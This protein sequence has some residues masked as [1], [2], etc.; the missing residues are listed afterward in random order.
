MLYLAISKTTRMDG[1]AQKGAVG[2]SAVRARRMTVAGSLALLLAAILALCLA[3]SGGAALSERA[4]ADDQ[5]AQLA[6]PAKTGR[7]T[8]S[9]EVE[10][11]N[12][13]KRIT[14]AAD[15]S[16]PAWPEG[17]QRLQGARALDTM[18][19]IVKAGNFKPG[20]TVVLAQ[21]EGYWDALTAAGI[22]GLLDAPVLMTPSNEL[23]AQTKG[24]LEQLRPSKIIVCGGENSVPKATVDAAAR[25][26]GTSRRSCAARAPRPQRLRS[27]Y[28]GRAPTGRARAGPRPRSSP[29]RARSR[30]RSRRL[31]WPTR[32][33][34]RSSS[35]STTGRRG[36]ASFRSRPSRL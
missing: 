5:E 10:G 2:S 9:F 27:T 1:N 16:A 18:V 20:G 31:L 36:R 33:T 3:A 23:A 19:A 17:V 11:Q 8:G 12:A 32:C 35:P 14:P 21:L 7:G 30:M 6:P 13:T 25:E 34:C 22:A 28:T 26:A 4:Y 15:A 29:P 24:L